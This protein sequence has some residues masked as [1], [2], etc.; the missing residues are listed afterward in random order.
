MK[1]SFNLFFPPN[2][3][4]ETL[5]SN[6]NFMEVVKTFEQSKKNEYE[7]NKRTNV[8]VSEFSG[9]RHAIKFTILITLD[10][11]VA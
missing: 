7:T 2:S 10:N 4:R 1:I 8:F 9:K 3:I 11:L 5:Y 6:C